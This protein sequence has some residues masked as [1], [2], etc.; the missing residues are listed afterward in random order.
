[1]ALTVEEFVLSGVSNSNVNFEGY[2]IEMSMEWI[3]DK[4]SYKY[5]IGPA[6]PFVSINDKPCYYVYYTP[7]NQSLNGLTIL[8]GQVKENCNLPQTRTGT[9][10]LKLTDEIAKITGAVQSNI[11][12]EAVVDVRG[13]KKSKFALYRI[14][15][16]ETGMSWYEDYGYRPSS[17]DFEQI[18]K[19]RLGI[20][21]QEVDTIILN[22]YK[23]ELETPPVLPMTAMRNMTEERKNRLL[24]IKTRKNKQNATE[25]KDVYRE[26]F[27]EWTETPIREAIA[28][29]TDCEKLAKLLYMFNECIHYSHMLTKRYVASEIYLSAYRFQDVQ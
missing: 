19:T 14:A 22:L 21:E 27:Q 28:K 6:Q 13:C 16:G 15:T 9:Y 12:D 29:E 23:K 10:L 3:E 1:M 26:V 17:S 20:R 4:K 11:Q 25:R 18:V 2:V 5:S 7:H 24:A 8:F